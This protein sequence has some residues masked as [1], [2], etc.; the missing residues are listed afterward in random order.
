MKKAIEAI[1]DMIC[2]DG[3]HCRGECFYL[4]LVSKGPFCH[5]FFE[6]IVNEIRHVNCCDLF[7]K[8]VDTE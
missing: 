8:D 3:V 6:R 4:K 1:K 7:K 5:L 2:H